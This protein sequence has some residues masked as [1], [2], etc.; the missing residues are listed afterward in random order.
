[1]VHCALLPALVLA[2]PVVGGAWLDS[3][4]FSFSAIAVSAVV[5]AGA[6]GRG[7]RTHGSRWPLLAAAGGIAL[8]LAGERTGDHSLA[9]GI[10]LSLVGGA[11]MVAVHLANLRLCRRCASCRRDRSGR[12]DAVGKDDE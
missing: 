6:L 5:A 12:V 9:A 8:L 1:V 3:D 2:A 7:Y 11:T 4:A 10:L